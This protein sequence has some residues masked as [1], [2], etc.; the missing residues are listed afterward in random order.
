MSLF[1]YDYGQA[2]PIAEAMPD[3]GTVTVFTAGYN[4]AVI[5]GLR[6]AL[7]GASTTTTLLLEVFDGTD[8]FA[9]RGAKPLEGFEV[10]REHMPIVLS[11]GWSL[12]A[13]RGAGDPIDI[14]GIV[15]T[16]DGR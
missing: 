6:A 11:P 2:E 16:Q 1:S 12:R 8:A 3:A 13:T 9:I 14:T 10:V 7:K 15:V 5:L 4:Q